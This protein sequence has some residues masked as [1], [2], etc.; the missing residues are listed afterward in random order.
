MLTGMRVREVTSDD[1]V[2]DIRL[3]LSRYIHDNSVGYVLTTAESERFGIAS[4]AL[5]CYD[6]S[7]IVGAIHISTPFE[8]V[9]TAI[10]KG[11]PNDAVA[12]LAKRVRMMY[13][14]AVRDDHRRTGIGGALLVAAEAAAYAQGARQVVG[15]AQGDLD[16]LVPFYEKHGYE[17]LP[18]GASLD[19]QLGNL[20]MRLPVEI[21]DGRPIR[22]FRKRL[23][24]Q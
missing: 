19:L 20:T 17:V 23:F 3:F 11:F 16:E 12:I 13:N 9:T 5:A 21:L 10:Q 18:L 2:R 4:T 8:D 15:V 14:V 7:G 6:S 22:W 24:L 1:K